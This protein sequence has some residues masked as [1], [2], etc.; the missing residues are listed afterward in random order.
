[1]KFIHFNKY[2]VLFFGI[3]I[4]SATALLGKSEL[5]T[6]P[7]WSYIGPDNEEFAFSLSQP[8]WQRDI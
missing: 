8:I 5:L 7:K 2:P 4:F 3:V 6:S 1:M